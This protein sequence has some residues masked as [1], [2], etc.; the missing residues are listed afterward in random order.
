LER[1]TLTVQGLVAAPLTLSW[2][3]FAALPTVVSVSDFHCVE[4]WSVLACKWEGVPFRMVVDLVTPTDAAEFVA[5]SCEDGYATSLAL[6]E[7]NRDGVL[8]AS[9]LDGAP[10]DLELG[11]PM[12]LV[13][14]DKYAYKSAMWV[15]AIT[16]TAEKELGFWEKRGY[17]DSADPWQN[18]RLAR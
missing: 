2:P 3:A 6:Q 12:R 17:S 1:W 4:G 14:P 7:L 8:L 5:F 18:D 10:L 13:V 11:G 9:K 15:T 16:F